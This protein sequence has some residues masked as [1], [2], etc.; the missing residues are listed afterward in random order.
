MDQQGRDRSVKWLIIVGTAV[1]ALLVIGVST[2]WFGLHGAERA[3]GIG[4]NSA[5]AANP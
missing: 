5:A 2:E 4:S 3:P 1:A